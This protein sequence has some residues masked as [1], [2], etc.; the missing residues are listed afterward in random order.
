VEGESE[1]GGRGQLQDEG[2]GNPAGVRSGELM[3]DLRQAGELRSK[4]RADG[5]KDCDHR[6]LASDLAGGRELGGLGGEG[7]RGHLSADSRGG[8]LLRIGDAT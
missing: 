2:R 3:A 1:E 6:Q 4:D 7:V 8:T 5:Q